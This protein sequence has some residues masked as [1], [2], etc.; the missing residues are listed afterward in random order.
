MPALLHQ[1]VVVVAEKSCY[2]AA[3][4]TK[5]FHHLHALNT[6]QYFVVFD[7]RLY[8]SS[9]TH[10]LS[11]CSKLSLACQEASHVLSIEDDN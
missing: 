6:H 1:V 2:I 4:I 5:R 3:T 8:S 11:E 7:E 9:N 10:A